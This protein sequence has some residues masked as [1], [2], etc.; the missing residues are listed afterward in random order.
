MRSFSA[1]PISLLV[2]LSGFSYP[3]V[4]GDAPSDGLQI[5]HTRPVTCQRPTQKGDKI[6]VH[7]KGTLQSTG[8]EFDE[9]YRRGAPFSFVLGAGQVIKG[10]DEGLLDMCVGEG[11]KLIIPPELAY[12]SRGVGSIPAN[13]VLV[14]ETELMAIAG[15]PVETTSATPRIT[16]TSLFQSV[17]PTQPGN[18]PFTPTAI[19]SLVE[20]VEATP[21]PTPTAG[22]EGGPALTQEKQ[23]AENGECRLLG[24]FALL[25]Q[26]ALGAIA[27]LSLVFKRWRESPR[28]PLK[29]WFFDVS[30]QVIGSILLHILNLLMSMF[31]SGDF[32]AAKQA[33]QVSNAAKADDGRTPNPCS[34]YLL[35]LAI[36]VSLGNRIYT[37][38]CTL[39]KRRQP[40]AYQ[41]SLSCSASSTRSSCTRH[42]PAHRRA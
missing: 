14:F 30:K 13:S 40:S 28:R 23:G 3:V 36:D 27:L 7:Y 9:S 29:I 18:K 31:S 2:L 37:L 5:E 8:V 41:S 15:V 35:N 19:S 25:V 39:T 6:S 33:Q 11:R 34:F 4:A 22:S 1:L 17:V 42:S 12:G 20:D 38:M 16:A 32:D 10:W 24:P 21:T 26:A